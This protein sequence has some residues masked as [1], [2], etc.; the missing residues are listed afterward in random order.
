M[1]YAQEGPCALAGV[2]L[3]VARGTTLAVVGRTGAGKSSLLLAALRQV[4][5][6]FGR[7]LGQGS[8]AMVYEARQKRSGRE[9]AV[10]V[11]TYPSLRPLASP[12]PAGLCR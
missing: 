3:E 9:F 8:S 1:R 11:R 12:P 7:L 6:Q 10:K 2:T 4:P 5:L